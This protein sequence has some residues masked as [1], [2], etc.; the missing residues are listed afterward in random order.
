[1]LDFVKEEAEK[2]FD[3]A[4]G[5]HDWEHTLRVYGLCERI[6]PAEKAD[7]DVLRVAAY[8]H[9]IGR[10]GQDSTLG[11]V[12]HAE[13]GAE[14]ARLIVEKLPISEDQKTNIIHCIKT[15]RFRGKCLPETTEAK[16]LFD[17]DK[18]DAIGAVGVARAFLFAGEV[19]ARLHNPDMKIE[20]TMPYSRE[21]TGFRE[22]KVKLCK[23]RD[24]ILTKEGKKLADERHAF[25]EEFF[26]RFVEEYE[27]KR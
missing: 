22:Y 8:L 13:K 3:G 16:A 19:G 23:I 1:M 5:S 12:C 20:E 7:M 26:K 9:D 15:H 10:A 2:L 25:M 27:G 4:K 18:L 14:M 11:S 21:D 24:R 6:G 17:A